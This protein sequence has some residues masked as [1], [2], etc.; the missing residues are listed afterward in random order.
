[1]AENYVN[2][3]DVAKK[4]HGNDTYMNLAD[5]P[6]ALA[7]KNAPAVSALYWTQENMKKKNR[8]NS[9]FFSKI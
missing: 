9:K 5:L 3:A 7:P 2:L 8:E 4:E 1:M 6:G